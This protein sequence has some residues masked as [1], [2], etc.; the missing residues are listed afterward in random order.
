MIIQLSLNDDDTVHQIWR[1]QHIAYRLEAEL[2][3]FK[4]IPPL[5]DTFDSIKQCGE[6][7]FGCLSEDGELMGAIAVE[8]EEPNT[9]TISRMMVHPDFFQKG[10]ASSLLR[11]VFDTFSGVDRF[12]VS[13]GTRNIPA[14]NLYS[15]HGFIPVRRN[16][17]APGV[18]LTTF[19]R[20][21][22]KEGA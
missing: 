3:G 12:I 2:I 8:Q 5:L 4:Q 1:L 20:D 16:E 21:S 10:I 9:L 18:E 22:M 19:Y 13:T 17:V 6:Q 15:K 14:V 7:F 11:Y